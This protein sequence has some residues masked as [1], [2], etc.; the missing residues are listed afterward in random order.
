MEKLKAQVVQ[1]VRN[2]VRAEQAPARVRQPMTVEQ[3]LRVAV[4]SSVLLFVLLALAALY[5]MTYG[6]HAKQES[7]FFVCGCVI[8]L[9]NVAI[10]IRL[11]IK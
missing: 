11:R 4:V 3:R 5:G 6:Y 2:E 1:E 7:L 9:Y 10:N 8:I